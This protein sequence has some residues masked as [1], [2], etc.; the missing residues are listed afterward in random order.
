MGNE[1]ASMQLK[2]SASKPEYSKIL[3]FIICTL[4]A[5]F[6]L[7]EFFLRVMPGAVAHELMHDFSTRAA[8]LGI[9][10]S[11]FYWGYTPMQVP[12]GLLLDKFGPKKVLTVSVFLCA[13]SS[14]IFGMTSSL[15]IASFTRL[16][17]GV[18]SSFAY[19]GALILAARWYPPKNFAFIAGLVQVLGCFGAFVGL[20]PVA[21]AAQTIGWRATM[22]IAGVVCI[23]LSL[24]FWL[25]I[26]D[27]PPKH[28][29]HTNKPSFSLRE[30]LN[31]VCRNKQTWWIALHA[32]T[33]WAPITVIGDLWGAPFLRAEYGLSN[34]EATS[35]TTI[36]WVGIAVGGPIL[37]WASDAIG[38]RCKLLTL[39]SVLGLISSMAII[40]WHVPWFFLMLSLFTFGV[41]ASSQAITFGALQD[42]MPPH[43]AGTA[44]GFNNMAIIFG[45][46]TV[47]PLVSYL[48]D[49]RLVDS[50]AYAAA[51]Y[52]AAF[53]LVPLIFALGI[54]VSKFGIRETH[55][56]VQYE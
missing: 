5:F 42:H 44:V 18:C 8:G 11:M 2:E 27:Y 35:C 38:S 49:L 39:G 46:I 43:V 7:Y 56:K 10:S 33:T 17:L 23:V 36:L 37:G 50:T 45:G 52:R 3:P 51:D 28:P 6:Y 40:Y 20:A 21:A 14:F 32:F 30:Q 12:A 15:T 4:A 55:C 19:L 26:R 34:V 25:V 31:I 29:H 24:L 1:N 41:A 54:L 9:L 48:L 16:I 13:L 53:F 22:S 47:Q